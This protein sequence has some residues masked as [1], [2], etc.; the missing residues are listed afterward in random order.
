VPSLPNA[1]PSPFTFARRVIDARSEDIGQH[2]FPYLVPQNKICRS[3][4]AVNRKLSSN[5][6]KERF[7]RAGGA[8]CENMSRIPKPSLSN[9]EGFL[10]QLS[11]T[12][13]LLEPRA[14]KIK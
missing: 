10:G 1:F 14:E 9:A 13:M 5:F 4:P 12:A 8:R 2:P 11:S 6:G 3:I 7:G